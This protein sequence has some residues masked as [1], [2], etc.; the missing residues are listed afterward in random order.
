MVAELQGKRPHSFFKYFLIAS[1]GSSFSTS[2]Y[3][4]VKS[5]PSFTCVRGARGRGT[6]GRAGLRSGS[7]APGAVPTAALGLEV[8]GAQ[9][10]W[11][12]TKILCPVLLTNQAPY[13]VL[14]VLLFSS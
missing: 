4:P 9:P 8:A 11:G 10:Q 12:I 5:I 14:F 7:P 1:S 3:V 6:A 13:F 2:H